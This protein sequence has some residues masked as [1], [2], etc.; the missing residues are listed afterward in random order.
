[1]SLMISVSGIRGIVGQ[2]MTPQLAVDIGCAFA[3]YVH[4]GSVVLACDSR[5]SGPMIRA[6]VLAGLLSG[7]C[8][9][10]DLGIVSTPGAALMV[11]ELGAGG[12]IVI[13]A[14]HNPTSWNGIKF[15]T[16]HGTAPP[17]DQADDIIALY[18]SRN[19]AP[20]SVEKVGSFTCDDST[21]RRHVD[22][23]LGII[24]A[25]A[26][27]KKRFRVVLDSVCGAGGAGGRM[28]L[29]ALGCEVT[30]LHEEPSGRFPH[31]PEP[32][33]ENLGELCEAVSDSKADVGFAQDPD[34]DRLAI[35]DETG[36]YIGEE[37]TLALAARQTF[38]RRPGSAVANLSTSR[39]ID[40][41]AQRA[42]GTCVV[43]RSAVGEANVVEAM[44][45]H[46]CVIG[47]EGNGGVIDPRVVYVRDSLV[48]MA[49][50]LQLMAD[51]GS[52]L[53]RIV[54][55]I[56]RYHMVK[57]KFTCDR[58]RI[59]AVLAAVKKEFADEKLNDA[60]GV[61]IDWPMGWVHVRGSNTEPIMRVIAEADS[62][63]AT[64]EIIGRIR[65]LV[66]RV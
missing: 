45:R 7:G 50:A 56:P 4:S 61:R 51:E 42:G 26:V 62:P 10:V 21:H 29:E 15:L 11:N 23:V 49:L 52:P 63:A 35:V 43:H 31:P 19:F 33:A 8:K 47:G 6:A 27:A 46:N 20:V 37:Y 66:D 59:N 17:K 9:V 22:K 60:D 12:G 25:Q 65:G 57:Q 18:R 5:P 39:M 53:S 64:E 3:A 32:L 41:V 36:C 24:D 44:K 34:A 13:T 40:A 2:T 28:L 58:E 30:Y 1:M 14:S 16:R 48:A 55:E 38:G 54:S